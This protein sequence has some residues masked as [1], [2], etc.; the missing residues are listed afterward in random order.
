MFGLFC[1]KLKKNGSVTTNL[2]FYFVDKGF[3]LHERIMIKNVGLMYK[4]W[5]ISFDL[6]LTKPH[7]EIFNILH[8]GDDGGS[9]ILEVF[10]VI[11]SNALDVKTIINGKQHAI[12]TDEITLDSWT[13]VEIKQSEEPANVFEFIIRINYKEIHCKQNNEPTVNN[14]VKVYASYGQSQSAGHARIRNIIIKSYPDSTQAST[15]LFFSLLL[16]SEF[17]LIGL[18]V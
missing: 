8:V 5:S 12:K 13:N 3:E 11:N 4:T 2:L 10:L 18:S 16:A 14:D 15:G 17:V 7:D 6:M 9:K 1:L